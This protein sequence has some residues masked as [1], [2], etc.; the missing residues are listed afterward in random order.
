MDFSL[1][2]IN[3]FY[4]TPEV[5]NDSFIQMLDG[6]V[7]W[8]EVLDT[9]GHPGSHWTYHTQPSTKP[10]HLENKFLNRD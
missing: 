3:R 8:N 7:D 6:E 4:Q 2:A 1:E 5:E 9:I 10:R